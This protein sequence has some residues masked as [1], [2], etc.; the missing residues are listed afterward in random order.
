MDFDLASDKACERSQAEPMAVVRRNGWY[1]PRPV[2]FLCSRPSDTVVKLY[3][4]NVCVW[5]YRE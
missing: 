4:R 1:F 2:S 5:D 3:V